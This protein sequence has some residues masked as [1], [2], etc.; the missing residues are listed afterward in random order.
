MS[1]LV[2]IDLEDAQ[3]I[4]QNIEE[5]LQFDEDV[6]REFWQVILTRLNIAIRHASTD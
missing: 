3:A 2:H 4:A 1:D 6:D 5:N